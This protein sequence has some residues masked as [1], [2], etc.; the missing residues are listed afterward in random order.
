[1]ILRYVQTSLSLKECHRNDYILSKLKG[2][3]LVSTK[4][5]VS[6][7]FMKFSELKTEKLKTEEKDK[8]IR[9]IH[10]SLR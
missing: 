4:K 9:F 2:N 5:K 6:T 1:M 8:V 7:Q 3:I 10:L